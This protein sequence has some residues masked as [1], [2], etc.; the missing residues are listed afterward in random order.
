[1]NNPDELTAVEQ[2]GKGDKYYGVAVMLVTMPGLPMFGHGQIEGFTEKYGM[3]YRRAYWDEH[4]DEDM[5]RRHEAQV[6]PLMRRRRLFSGADN[7]AFYDFAVPEGWVDENVFA[8]SNRF[9]DERAVILYNNAYNTTRGSIHTSTAINIGSREEPN[10]VRRN[11]ADALALNTNDGVYYSFRDHAI[12]LEYLRTGRQIRDEG[13]FAELHAY[14][15]H[16]FLDWREIHDT[17][18]SWGELARRLNGAPVPSVHETY[19]EMK[20]EP[21]LIPFRAVLEP[22]LLRG[23]VNNK[24]EARAQF[25]KA[26]THFYEAVKTIIGAESKVEKIVADVGREVDALDFEK[27]L[28]QAGLSADLDREITSIIGSDTAA[29]YGHI[30]AARTAVRYVGR[31]HRPNEQADPQEITVQRLNDWLLTKTIEKSFRGYCNNDVFAHFDSLLAAI[32]IAHHDLLKPAGKI[33]LADRMTAMLDNPTVREYLQF[34]RHNGVFWMKK[35]QLERMV[36]GLLIGRLVDLHAEGKLTE[37]SIKPVIKLAKDIFS[38]A[39]RAG[40]Q[41]EK[42]LENLK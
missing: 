26:I 19:L 38:V 31:L 37:S 24:A 20:L 1:M 36:G 32:I 5:V 14:Q 7:F 39:E 18:G 33:S 13:L 29:S 30:L 23:I 6:F 15:F 28:K 40:Y 22:E 21:V 3:E 35:E 2:F 9:H 11:I 16:A 25:K 27:H 42:T 8:Y 41:V 34:N 17:D 12:G 10:L 4:V